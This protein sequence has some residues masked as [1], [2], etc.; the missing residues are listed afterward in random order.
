MLAETDRW[1]SAD[2]K[3]RRQLAL[4]EVAALH[5]DKIG[6]KLSKPTPAQVVC[7]GVPERGPFKP[8]RDRYCLIDHFASEKGRLRAALCV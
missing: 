6:V 3:V 1:I 4:D 2:D 5:L 8:D 7:L